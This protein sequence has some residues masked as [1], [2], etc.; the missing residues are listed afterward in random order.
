L[1]VLSIA[2]AVV[3]YVSDPKII[4]AKTLFA[5][6]YHELTELEG[7]LAGVHNYCSAVKENADGIIFLRKI[8]RGGADRSYG[9]EVAKIAGL[10]KEVIERA[11]DLLQE[12]LKNDLS[13]VTQS[14]EAVGDVMKASEKKK[15]DLINNEDSNQLSFFGALSDNDI[16][17]EIRNMELSAMTP[18]EAMNKLD[19]IQKKVKNRW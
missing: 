7:K 17:D 14:I 2:W 3:E 18:I 13:T 10:P 16:I 15:A 11:E 12:I 9:I 6:H 8:I 1:T 4:G 5:T 19:S